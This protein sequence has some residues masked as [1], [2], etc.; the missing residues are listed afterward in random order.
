MRTAARRRRAR[1]A[2]LGHD[3]VKEHR[4]ITAKVGY[5]SQRF[6][7]YGD[8]SIDENIAFFAEIHGVRDY[9]DAPRSRCSR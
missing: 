5:L 3:P 8:L 1:C 2:S 7:L 6:S 4:A 9:A